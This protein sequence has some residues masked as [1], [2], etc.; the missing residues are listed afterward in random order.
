MSDGATVGAFG[1][2]PRFGS[3]GN[4]R[5]YDIFGSTLASVA[6]CDCCFRRVEHACAVLFLAIHSVRTDFSHRKADA[7]ASNCLRNVA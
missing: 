1:E 4:E 2:P 5:R 6:A 7:I 3:K